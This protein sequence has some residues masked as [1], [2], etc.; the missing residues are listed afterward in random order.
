M[1]TATTP[2]KEAIEDPLLDLDEVAEILGH[3]STRSVRRIIARGELPQ[4]IKILST[5]RLYRSE[6]MAYLERL[7]QKR[8]LVARRQKG[9]L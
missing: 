6:V 8:D 1:Q 3:I 4:P 2:R 9:S 5:P 7:K